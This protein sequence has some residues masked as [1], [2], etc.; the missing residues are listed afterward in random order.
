[1]SIDKKK[2]HKCIR[3]YYRNLN[4]IIAN[5]PEFQGRWF[6]RELYKQVADWMVYCSLTFVDRQTGEEYDAGWYDIFTSRWNLAKE[7]NE[8]IIK[9]NSK[10]DSGLCKL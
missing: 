10:C 9:N 4:R 1:M 7:F 3:K 2:Q 5:D 6:I 8:F